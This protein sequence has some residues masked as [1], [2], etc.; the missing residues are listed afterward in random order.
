MKLR[1]TFLSLIVALSVCSSA[2]AIT[3][4][5]TFSGGPPATVQFSVQDTGSGLVSIVVTQSQN[6]DTVVPPFTLGTT[7]EVTLTST[8]IDQTLEGIISFMVTTGGPGGITETETL[9]FTSAGIIT[10]AVPEP[11]TLAIMLLGLIA[12]P[13]RRRS[14]ARI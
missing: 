7:D 10:A 11:A 9:R 8:L 3:I 1:T 12:L 6:A 13:F 2:Y 5:E 14:Q 4:S